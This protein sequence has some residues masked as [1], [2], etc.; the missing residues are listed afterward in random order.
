MW[1]IIEGAQPVT[2]AVRTVYLST[3]Y[4]GGERAFDNAPLWKGNRDASSFDF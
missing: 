4:S 2:M 3:P 1:D